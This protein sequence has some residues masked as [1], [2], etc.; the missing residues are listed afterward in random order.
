M[1]FDH[2]TYSLPLTDYTTMFFLKSELREIFTS[3]SLSSEVSSRSVEA[4][5]VSTPI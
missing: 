4:T 1:N 3:E 2:Y 5:L